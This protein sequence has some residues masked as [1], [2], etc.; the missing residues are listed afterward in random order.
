[1]RA[2]IGSAANYVKPLE[3]KNPYSDYLP[4]LAPK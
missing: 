3:F 4:I 2:I 1:M